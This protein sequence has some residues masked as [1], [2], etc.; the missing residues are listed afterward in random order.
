MP[1]VVVKLWPRKS[2]AQKQ[3]LT[4]I[5]SRGVMEILGYGEDA[6][7]VAFE[8]IAPEDW[9]KHVYD[10]NILSK[11]GQLT[12]APGYGPLPSDQRNKP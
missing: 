11:W 8:E 12:K 10:P 9:S 4:D 1:H 6:A 7:S 2:D 5:L 3:A